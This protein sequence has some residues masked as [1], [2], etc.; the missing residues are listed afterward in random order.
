MSEGAVDRPIVEAEQAR[1]IDVEDSTP[2]R[3]EPARPT[4]H[5]SRF[6]A[7]YLVLAVVAGAAIGSF[8]VLLAR[9]DTPPAPAWSAFQ[10]QGSSAARLHQIVDTI[11]PRYRRK[12]GTQ[13]VSVSVT[14][15]QAQISS[16]DGQSLITVPVNR[17]AF[18][19][20][21]DFRVV[22]SGDAL[23]FTLCGNGPNCV[24]D[25]GK[26]SLE[27][28]Q[29]VQRQ[30]LELALYTFKYVDGVS[31]VTV[32]LP[33]SF[34]TQKVDASGT[35]ELRRTA[36][37][38]RP[39]DVTRELGQPLV[40]TLAPKTPQIGSTKAGDVSSIQRLSEPHIYSYALTQAQDG[41]VVLVLKSAVG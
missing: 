29:L 41:A 24:I 35:P 10:P 20:G 11:P 7:V 25:T 26:P 22:D 37:F 40:M 13:L 8:V 5:R 15:P 33:P 17:I 32:L 31:S 39:D 19:Q 16:S 28:F 4:A 14:D 1:P 12:D 3:P 6:A 30:A 34:D 18:E 38:L 36:L 23:Q 27:R 2:T 21:G 9:P